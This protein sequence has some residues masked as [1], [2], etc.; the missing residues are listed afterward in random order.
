MNEKT[1][2]QIQVALGIVFTV[3]I[4][5]PF[6]VV[7]VLSK[8]TL[9]FDIL[10]NLLIAIILLVLHLLFLFQTIIH[11]RKEYYMTYGLLIGIIASVMAGIGQIDFIPLLSSNENFTLVLSLLLWSI[12]YLLIYFFFESL[13]SSGV[14]TKRF[15]VVN[16]FFLLSLFGHLAVLVVPAESN[17]FWVWADL[18]YSGLGITIFVFGVWVLYVSYKQVGG[19]Q[20]QIIQIVG[21]SLILMGFI[22]SLFID[23]NFVFINLL[24]VNPTDFIETFY[25]DLFKVL[26]II[27]FTSS[28]IREID[29]IYRLPFPIY[30]IIFFK[31]DSGLSL[32]IT[33]V[34]NLSKEKP[35][36][37][38]ENLITGTITAVRTLLQ[39]GVGSTG[40][41]KTIQSTDQTIVIESNVH[42]SIAV[43]TSK[44]TKVLTNSIK[45]ALQDFTI[46]YKEKLGDSHAIEIADFQ[47]TKTV[48]KKAFPYLNLQN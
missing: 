31:S 1:I 13:Y 40:H 21:L 10:I 3:F 23:F 44:T 28:Y 12:T 18:G 35:M 19:E 17:V 30:T 4:F 48:L 7:Y 11:E 29:Y 45:K 41:L 27:L 37:L 24:G 46:K 14:N 16:F 32:N 8:A 36:K 2:K 38:D 25:G 47:Q 9:D 5:I 6:L 15:F 20:T 22:L 42:A 39:E 26:G 43:I 34:V 33:N